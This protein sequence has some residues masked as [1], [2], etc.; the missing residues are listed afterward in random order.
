M[1]HGNNSQAR[2]DESAYRYWLPS[3]PRGRTLTSLPIGTHQPLGQPSQAT[4]K[5]P[6][7]AARRLQSPATELQDDVPRIQLL[8]S[9]ADIA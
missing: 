9:Q 6:S 7:Q 5:H 3:A 2:S 8:M 1:F 4:A